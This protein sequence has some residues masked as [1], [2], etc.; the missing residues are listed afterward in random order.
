ERRGPL[1]G[2][3][4]EESRDREDVPPPRAP[5]RGSLE[6]A[7]LLERVDAHV[8]VG[9]DADPDSALA[10]FLHGAE[11]IA[12]V[13]LGRRADADACACLPQ[14]LELF[15]VGGGRLLPEALEAAP[16]VG[17]EQ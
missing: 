11:A 17:R 3:A 1:V 15:Q 5:A 12:E 7:Q 9:A 10:D 16:R 13:R 2:A 6:L 4:A 14:G 8:R